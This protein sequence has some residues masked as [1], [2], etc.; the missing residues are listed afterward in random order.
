CPV[1]DCDWGPCRSA[2]SRIQGRASDREALYGRPGD[3]RDRS[4]IRR[5]IAAL[6]AVIGLCA[7]YF[8]ML[9]FQTHLIFPV[10]AV[11]AAGPLPPRAERLS[12]RTPDGEALEGIRIPP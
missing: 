9:E 5:L 11:P 7:A 1:R 3:A 4:R 10:H 6:I 12:V 2:A 8:A